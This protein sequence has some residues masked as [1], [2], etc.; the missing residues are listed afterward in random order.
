MRVSAIRPVALALVSAYLFTMC[1]PPLHLRAVAWVAL[2]PLLLALNTSSLR[3]A[4]VLAFVWAVVMACGLTDWLPPA[5]SLY[6]EQPLWLGIALFLA[7]TVSMIAVYFA[8]FGA[9]C[10]LASRRLAWTWPLAVAAGWVAAEFACSRMLTGN[11]WGLVGYTQAGLRPSEYSGYGALALRIVQSADLGGVYLTSFVIV[12]ANAALAQLWQTRLFKDRSATKTCILAVSLIL[13]AGGYGHWRLGH[14]FTDSASEVAIV[15]GNVDLGYRWRPSLYGKNLATY[16]DLTRTVLRD[17]DVALVFWPENAMTFFVDRRPDFRWT[18]AE[19]TEPAGVQLVAGG[20]RYA[21][22]QQRP[23]S[24][25]NS[26][27]VLAPNGEVIATYDKQHLLPFAEYFPFGSLE[28]LRRSFGRV[29]EISPGPRMAPLPTVA[30]QAAVTICNEVMFARIV[31]QRML[32]G[33]GYLLNL[34]ND[35][36]MRSREFAEH[37]LA[38]ATLRSIEQ[39]RFLIRTSTSGP[40]AIVDAHGRVT[41]RTE[42]FERA[43]LTARLAVGHSQS[44]YAR[45]GDIFA[46]VCLVFTAATGLAWLRRRPR[47]S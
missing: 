28:L 5:I 1:F 18:I 27:F 7:A 47:L 42:P 11:P 19:V 45:F 30:G 25:Y 17:S 12:A 41:A 6:Y 2:A 9:Y 46:W 36:W 37:Q 38:L 39:R 44:V 29:S 32:D 21:E 43:T 26:A 3:R 33:G 31:R 13:A 8:A 16:L 23:T 15:Q 40:S 4:A 10:S 34:A 20:P 24:Y 22:H 35:G 14:R